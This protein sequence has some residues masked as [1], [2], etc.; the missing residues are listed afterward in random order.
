MIANPD[1]IFNDLLL[2]ISLQV[3]KLKWG[4]DDS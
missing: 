2:N 1:S 3:K 4:R